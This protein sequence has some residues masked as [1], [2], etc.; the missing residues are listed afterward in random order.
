M[1]ERTPTSIPGES[2]TEQR[3]YTM[4]VF[5]STDGKHTVSV[6]I[7]NPEKSAIA[8]ERAKEIFTA[9]V[10][11]YGM[12]HDMPSSGSYQKKQPQLSDFTCQRH[13]TRMYLNKNGKPYHRN[14]DG[15]FCNGHGFPSEKQESQ[16]NV[17][18]LPF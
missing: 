13:S 10:E 6:N 17:N 18:D 1:T 9:V 16:V 15:E 12:K 2:H 5:F 7:N 8:L 3:D 14:G 4:S 11:K